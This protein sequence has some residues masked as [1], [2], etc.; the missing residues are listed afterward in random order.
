[1]LQ[2]ACFIPPTLPSLR[3][4]SAI[5]DNSCFVLIRH[6]HI[7]SLLL[8]ILHYAFY[9]HQYPHPP[10]PSDHLTSSFLPLMVVSSCSTRASRNVSRSPLLSPP[11]RVQMAVQIP[12][13]MRDVKAFASRPASE[14]T[15]FGGTSRA[16][17]HRPQYCH[18]IA[19]TCLL[20]VLVASVSLDW[21]TSEKNNTRVPT[22]LTAHVLFEHYAYMSFLPLPASPP[23]LMPTGASILTISLLGTITNPTKRPLGLANSGGD[24]RNSSVLMR[25]TLSCLSVPAKVPRKIRPSVMVIRSGFCRY[26]F[27]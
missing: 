7:A 9:M 15:G 6:L 12:L 20:D 27:I 13:S 22:H 25:R 11:Q 8:A 4:P 1:M 2:F 5:Y 21:T 23:L 26:R 24:R 14:V 3:A 19:E 18:G 10:S 17:C 16:W